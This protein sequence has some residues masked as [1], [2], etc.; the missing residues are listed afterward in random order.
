MMLFMQNNLF[1][2]MTNW[3]WTRL[4]GGGGVGAGG[5]KWQKKGDTAKESAHRVDVVGWGGGKVCF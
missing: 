5:R 1:L 4:R 2:K 3:P